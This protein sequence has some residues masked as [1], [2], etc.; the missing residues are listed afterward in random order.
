MAEE[1]APAK[2]S[3]R[4]PADQKPAD[5]KPPAT[6]PDSTTPGPDAR[7]SLAAAHALVRAFRDA[8]SASNYQLERLLNLLPVSAP[9]R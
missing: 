4:N 5:Q 8:E 3:A 6:E 7:A 2:P 9:R 1:T